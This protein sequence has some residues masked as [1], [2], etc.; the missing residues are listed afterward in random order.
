MK[1][2]R[3]FTITLLLVLSGSG[4]LAQCA[5]LYF[6]STDTVGCVPLIA[7]FTA[8]NFPAGSDFAW[9]FGGGY[10]SQSASDSVKTNIFNSVGNYTVKLKVYLPGG[11]I[12]TLQKSNYIAVSQ[13][14][15]AQFTIDKPLLC[16]GGDTVIFTDITAKSKSRNWLIDGVSY[17]N[18]PRVLKHY[19]NLTGY[20]SV[21]LLIRDSL[22][23]TALVNRDSAVN[24]VDSLILDFSSNFTPGCAP[25][26]VTFT[27]SIGGLATQT[28]TSYS[29]TLSGSSSPS[30]TSLSP[31][32][33]YSTQGS[34]DVTLTVTTNLGCTYVTTKKAFI[35][36]GSPVVVN[37]TAD[38][39]TVCRKQTIRL[40]NTTAGLPMPGQF[41]WVLPITATL[42]QGD[43]ASDTVYITFDGIGLFDMQLNYLYNSCS[44][45]KKVVNYFT[46]TPPVAFFTSV[47]RVNCTFP[48]TVNIIST[49]I[50]PATGT[51][52]Y[53]WTVY[54]VN[55]TNVLATATTQN[56]TFII[57]KFGAFDVRL[58]VA[59]SNGCSDTLRMPSFIIIDTAIGNFSAFPLVACPGQPIAFYNLTPV[60]SNKA[61]AR[62]RWIFYSLDSIHRLNFSLNGNDTIDNPIV[63]YDTAGRYNVRLEVSNKWG[64]GDT[65]IYYKF[66]TVGVPIANFSNA[67][68][69]ICAGSN[70]AFIQQT[71][72]LLST[73]LHTWSIQHA[74]SA[75]ITL[76]GVGT[77][78]LATF[79]VPGSYHVKYK[80]SNGI[81]CSD[82]LIK[83]NEVHVSGIKGGIASNKLTGC[84]QAVL[85]FTSSINY[86]FHYVNPSPIVQYEWSCSASGDGALSNGFTIANATNATTTIT[87][88]GIGTYKVY[89]KFTNSDG[90]SYID[91][92][93]A[94]MIR[95]GVKA[96]FD[97]FPVYCLDDTGIVF[98]TSLLKP[99]SYKWYSDG[100]ISFLP[101]DTAKN[102]IIVFSQRGYHPISLIT[103]S[104]DGCLDTLTQNLVITKPTADFV[105]SD[106]V[107]LCGPSLVTFRSR[108][109]SD[110][111]LYTWNFGDG[112]PLLKSTDSVIS[113]VFAINNGQS[114]FH[115]TL[116]VENYFGCKASKTKL[117][118]IRIL[119][120][121]PYF[122]ISNTVGCEPLTVHIVDSSRNV[123]KFYFSYGFGPIDS[124]TISDKIYTLSS[125]NLL[126]SVY[127]PYLFVTDNSGT[128]FQLYQPLDSIVVYSNPKASFYVNDRNDCAPFVV[129][130]NDSS[131]GAVRWKWDFNNDGLID[132]TTQNPTHTYVAAGNYAVKLIV[133]NSFGCTD[134]TLRL[135]YIEAFA[136]PTAL[137]SVSDTAVCPHT[138]IT[139]S[140]QS[141]AT[142][143]QV[144]YHWDFGDPF[145]LADT[146][147]QFNPAPYGYD[148]PGIY[149]VKL[150][151][152][153]ANGCTDSVV[154]INAVRVFDSLPPSQPEIY[155]VTVVNSN[156]IKIVWNI[157]TATD[158][159]AYTLYRSGGGPFSPL[160]TKSNKVDTSYLDNTGINVNT[161]PYSYSLEAVDYCQY[162]TGLSRLHQSIFINATTLT[163]NSNIVRWTGYRGWVSGSYSYQLYRSHTA[164]GGYLL[165]AQLTAFDTVFT[166]LNL[167]DS[168]YY[169]YVEAVQAGTQF[170]SR[171]NTDFNHPPF[172]ITNGV[173]EVLRATVL[174]D[175]DVLLEWDT[176]GIVNTN[177]KNYLVERMDANGT[178]KNLAVSTSNT[179]IDK[180]VDVHLNSYTYR[181]RMQDYCGN[182]TG[183]SNL[184]RSINLKVSNIDYA[185]Y[186]TWNAYGDWAKTIL[187]YHVE[188][189]DHT[190]NTFK[191]IAVLP[192][193]DTS[194]LD[195]TVTATDTAFCY[196][197]KAVEA[198]AL[199]DSS[200]S[201]M[202]CLFLPPKIFVPNAFSPNNDGINDV[203]Y[204]QG[205]FIQ[206]LTGKLP[207]DYLLRI[208]DRWGS[209]VFETNDLYKGWDG[210][211]RGQASAIGVY[212]YE[213]RATG[214]NRQRFNYKGTFQL[215]R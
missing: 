53:Q 74:D 64:C 135:N 172:Y 97:V 28:I 197:I 46:V 33:V 155:Y 98:N 107:I 110:V 37:F 47:D 65:V 163:Q 67:N 131:K 45:S 206:N 121:V 190:T 86:N 162:K 136:Q 120:P 54:D 119:G 75:N 50:L 209:L 16:N 130:F 133:S 205:L 138:A 76:T 203:F 101:A 183:A 215:L 208:Y 117:N 92:S 35:K 11:A 89:C 184:G 70:L 150:T 193:F 211:F 36:V 2:F 151:V 115:I 111:Y 21:T 142:S 125:P 7:K 82:S 178:F 175:K 26:N 134:S 194:Y 14:P 109:S 153:D 77:N 204:A 157:N 114:A 3:L 173:L 152:Q 66:I 8:A 88:S 85:N 139:F 15:V 160:V 185:V 83:S 60:F 56:P 87:F 6:A 124:L 154:H 17:L 81:Y 202:A 148:R 39:T 62:Y 182:T 143:S 69:N 164:V 158:F 22:G 180:Q 12:C 168:D 186:L 61:P 181:V 214:Y 40:I 144:K 104:V 171:S 167:C 165:H 9:D 137:F 95:I 169:Y 147:N 29:W 48:D 27:P 94:L 127:K 1:A 156:D 44:S 51:N 145:T 52:T 43:T 198:E 23:C 30:S 188:L 42:L 192:S 141:T 179:F 210:T 174:N 112:S 55:H 91:S 41:K 103:Q 166:D 106:T 161:Q 108:S 123:Y 189:Y 63:R 96:Q 71:L 170:I 99:V 58:I 149:S 126:Y 201:N 59:N 199:P 207:L 128:C 78:F 122:K 132:D 212:I 191:T 116:T 24:M 68:S 118:F 213:L 187:A 200:M 80:V 146:S 176:A 195:K 34:F 38:Y 113:H 57:N 19:F 84:K 20:K 31:T 49:S 13:K 100:A 32:V 105:A 18:A 129:N 159:A 79:A 10:S 5:G 90:C 72:P 196:R 140:N 73:L 102:P 25:F 177:R 4:V 93:A